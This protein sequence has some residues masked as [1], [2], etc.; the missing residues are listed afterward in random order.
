MIKAN[1]HDLYDLTKETVKW[2]VNQPQNWLLPIPSKE[3]LANWCKHFNCDKEDAVPI[4]YHM[5]LCIQLHPSFC[6]PLDKLLKELV[7]KED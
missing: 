1:K 3:V 5:N 6:K 2:F 7:C 4:W